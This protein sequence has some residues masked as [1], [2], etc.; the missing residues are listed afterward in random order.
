MIRDTKKPNNPPDDKQSEVHVA[1]WTYPRDHR[2]SNL[3]LVIK[4]K[5]A[6]GGRGYYLGSDT[7]KEALI[8]V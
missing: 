4:N 6:V 7:H 1:P 2:S 5:I 3:Q 8:L